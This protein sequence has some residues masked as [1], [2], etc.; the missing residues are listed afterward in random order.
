MRP[1][2]SGKPVRLTSGEFNETDPDFSPEDRLIAYRSERDGGGVYVQSAASGGSPKLIAKSRGKP[3]FSPDG[4]WIAYFTLSGSEDVS[5]TMGLG[6][7]FIVPAEG[8]APRR[9]QPS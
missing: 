9:I 3:R 5:A 6:Q 7:I 4:K 8:G 2:D 1:F